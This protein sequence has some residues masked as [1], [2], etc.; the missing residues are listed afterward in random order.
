LSTA[1]PRLVPRKDPNPPSPDFRMRA[2]QLAST[3]R[4]GRK[5]LFSVLDEEPVIGYLAGMDEDTY[6]VVVPETD[7]DEVHKV[8]LSRQSIL[9]FQLFDERTFQ[10]EPLYEKMNAIV[11]PFRDSVNSIYFQQAS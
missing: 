4:Q 5:I 6:F 3:V 7:K 8:L 2:R 9:L 1:A 11:K 10:E